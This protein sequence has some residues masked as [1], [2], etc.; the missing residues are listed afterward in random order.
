MSGPSSDPSSSNLFVPLDP[1][2]GEET[3]TWMQP[4]QRSWEAIVETEEG[5]LQSTTLQAQKE[6]KTRLTQSASAAG[7]NGTTTAVIEKGVIRYLYIIID[8]S[9][10]MN[11]NDMKPSRKAVTLDYLEAFIHE[12]FDQNPI[13]Q[14]GFIVSANKLAYQ[15]TEL[16][17][18]PSSQIAALREMSES[19]TQS[20][21]D[22]SLQNA[23]DMARHKLSVIPPYGAR[24]ILVIMAALCTVDPGD[25]HDTITQCQQSH[26]TCSVISLAAEMYVCT[27]LATTTGG[28]ATFIGR[29]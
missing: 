14:L 23:L 21:G 4:M 29:V 18:N 8:L 9:W 12:Y 5:G 28:K 25:I 15:V 22:F 10:C 6:R 27:L 13:S 7:A 2:G 1:N 11:Q 24:E 3:T 20:G 17:G 26:I 19:Q 16:S